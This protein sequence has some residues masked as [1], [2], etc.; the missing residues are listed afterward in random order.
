MAWAAG[1]SSLRPEASGHLGYGVTCPQPMPAPAHLSLPQT[2]MSRRLY[3]RWNVKPPATH[4]DTPNRGPVAAKPT[5]SS[6]PAVDC[7]KREWGRRLGGHFSLPDSLANFCPSEDMIGIAKGQ[8]DLCSQQAANASEEVED[9][10]LGQAIIVGPSLRRIPGKGGQAFGG[11]SCP[12]DI[13]K[14]G[15]VSS[16]FPDFW[17]WG[18]LCLSYE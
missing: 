1:D 10:V 13:T 12:L 11:K 7:E 16:L 15:C 5:P 2:P 4:K 6:C 9:V 3:K 14:A 17:R 18:S 8:R